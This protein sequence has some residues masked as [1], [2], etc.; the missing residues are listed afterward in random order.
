[1][2][3]LTVGL[4]LAMT[5]LL[6]A[7]GRRGAGT[8]NS[9]ESSD[10]PNMNARRYDKLMNDARGDLVCKDVQHRYVGDDIHNVSGCGK[11]KEYLLYCKGVCRWVQAPTDI[12]ATDLSCPLSSLKATKITPSVYSVDG[13]GQSRSY[14][15][16]GYTWTAQAGGA[17]SSVA[18]APEQPAAAQPQPAAQ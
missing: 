11:Q 15:L 16:Q 7:C 6:P 2:K 14:S 8:A 12:A 13:C 18:A 5:A 10:A 3:R 9:A 1:M 4:L 17:P